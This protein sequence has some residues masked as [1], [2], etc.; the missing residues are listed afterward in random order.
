MA[1]KTK[2]VLV[3][4]GR[5][6]R[7]HLR[8]LRDTPGFELAAV[9]DANATPPADLGAIPFLRTTAELAKVDYAAAVIATPTATHN[10]LALELIAAGKHL[11]VEK[12]V[13]SSYEHGLGVIEAARAKGVKL[14]VGHVERFNPA[15][16]KL[17]EVIREGWLGTPIHF[18]FTRVGGYP[19]TLLDGNNVLLDLAVH[20]IDVLRS[21]IGPLK[22]EHSTCHVTWREGVFDTA[23]IL[24]GAASG[25]SASVHVNWITPSKIRSVRVTGTRG[26]CF[27]DYILQTC[28]LLGGSL[29]KGIAPTTP[30]FD[31]LQ[32]L[33]RTT[34]R[35]QF[36]VQ[37]LEPLRA[38]AQQFKAFLDGAEAGELC[39]GSDALAAVLLAERAI[40][41]EAARARPRSIAPGAPSVE[42]AA[43]LPTLDAEWV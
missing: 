26:V 24:L 38:Q 34:D 18:A 33:Y 27:V 42:T 11:L 12:P 36:G 8:V 15:V 17:R 41:V 43:E 1:A 20:D 9:V 16:R 2:I 37:K 29:L 14:A 32:E 23:E 7:N 13:A 3:G 28:E 25:A 39:T 19:E 4:L 35:V 21:L 10:A 5:M 30:S 31:V 22:V 40:K 6:G